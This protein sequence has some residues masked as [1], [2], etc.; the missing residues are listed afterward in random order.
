MSS[1]KT[2]E[3]PGQ[4]RWREF[5]V[6]LCARTEASSE[7]QNF[8][9][10]GG[11]F[12]FVVGEVAQPRAVGL[13]GVEQD[14][15]NLLQP[16]PLHLGSLSHSVLW[17]EELQT[18]FGLGGSHEVVFREQGGGVLRWGRSFK[19]VLCFSTGGRQRLEEF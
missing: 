9:Q 10:I 18:G 3:P 16:D 7:G 6:R 11:D 4:A 13:N 2:I 5:I 12:D 19:S 14:S 8:V 15:H 1:A 17:I